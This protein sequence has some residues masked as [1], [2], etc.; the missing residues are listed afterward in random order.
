MTKPY[1][2]GY[3]RPPRESQFQP[4]QSGNPKGRPKGSKNLKTD[5]LDELQ[6]KVRVTEGS[7]ERVV[8]KQK[9]LVIS[10]AA[11][12]LKGEPRATAVLT[13]LVLRLLPQDD[14]T[15]AIRTLPQDDQEILTAFMKRQREDD[16]LDLVDEDA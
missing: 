5:L 3:R 2:V 1:K 13:D 11:R 12:A 4:G 7:S 14:L 15:E 8:T 10:L 9:A 16:P 6:K